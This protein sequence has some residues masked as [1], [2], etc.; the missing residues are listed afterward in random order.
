MNGADLIARL[1]GYPR[2]LCASPK[3][4]RTVRVEGDLCDE[5]SGC[6][7]CE[8]FLFPG[9]IHIANIRREDA[10]DARRPVRR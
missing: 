8:H 4:A 6:Y 10:W 7:M 3:C 1:R 5:C 2:F 9:H